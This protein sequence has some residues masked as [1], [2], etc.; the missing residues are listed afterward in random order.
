M[1][2]D[3]KPLSV[4]V[5][6]LRSGLPVDGGG[7]RWSLIA[8]RGE[9]R[10]EILTATPTGA[11]INAWGWLSASAITAFGAVTTALMLAIYF[12]LR[13]RRGSP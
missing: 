12:H 9:H 5:D 11:A 6:G 7:E 13:T 3:R 2:L 1:L 4:F 10:I 8:P